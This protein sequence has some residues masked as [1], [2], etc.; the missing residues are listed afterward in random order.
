MKVSVVLCTYNGERFLKEQLESIARQTRRPDEIILSDDRSTDA[1][2]KII[3]TF[4]EQ[5]DLPCAVHINETRLGVEANFSQALFRSTGDVIFFCDQD[6]VWK[7]Q[8]VEKMLA[9][10]SK[11]SN[12]ALVYSD[13]EIV[14]PILE[15][16]GY[17]LFTKNLRK[18]LQDGDARDVG[19]RLRYG[20]APGI[21]ASSMAFSAKVR[22]LAG[23]LPE[24]VAHDSWIAYFGYAVGNVVAI[25]E[26]LHYYRRHDQ[27]SGKSSSNA[28]V[29]G[30]RQSESVSR[31]ALF[32]EK[33]RLAQ[34]L[35][36]RMEWLERTQEKVQWD[37]TRFASLKSDAYQAART[38]EARRKIIEE[39]AWITRFCKGIT[40]LFKGEYLAI[41]G[42]HEKLSTLL[43]DI[44]G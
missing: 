27:T 1:T 41:S 20:H 12:V 35:Y 19:Q 38:L 21:K 18:K 29:P 13:G 17:T 23:P 43:K 2:Y 34:C 42:R 22:D 4:C 9:P 37:A 7:P 26:T 24:G 40:A 3:Q 5:F 44:R 6:D 36:E 39:R 28:L 14:G 15:A 31:A 30:L 33:A 11:D 25:Q 16:T 8:K 10:Y 32:A